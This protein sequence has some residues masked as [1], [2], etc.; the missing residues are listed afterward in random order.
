[1]LRIL[2]LADIHG[3]HAAATRILSDARQGAGGELDV[4]LL[5]GDL[6]RFFTPHQLDRVLDVFV[7]AGAGVQL[8]AV[9]GNCDGPVVHS[10]LGRRGLSLGGCGRVLAGVGFCGVPSAPPR[11]GQTWENSEVQL[12]AWLEQ[13]YAAIGG[14]ATK[15]LLTHSPPA[16][17][18]D[19]MP[20]STAVARAVK[21]LDFDIVVCGHIHEAH[22]VTR[23]DG[24]G[25]RITQVVNCGGAADGRYALIQIVGR[26][27]RIELR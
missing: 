7:G 1:M 5:A 9:A 18:P 24:D 3:S 22:G 6:T 23:V 17:I 14:A 4:V 25:G 26:E 12:A 19:G 10:E 15:V 27:V 20:G 11:Y 16:G 2:A 8:L 13:G 21:E